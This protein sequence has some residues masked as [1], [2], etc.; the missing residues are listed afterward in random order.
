MKLVLRL[1]CKIRKT[2]RKMLNVHKEKAKTKIGKERRKL[3]NFNSDYEFAEGHLIAYL[4]DRR[5]NKRLQRQQY[6]TPNNEEKV[7][8]D[9]TVPSQ[10]HHDH[11]MGLRNSLLCLFS[12]S[13][14]RCCS[15]VITFIRRVYLF[16]LTLN[17]F[18]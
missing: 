13:L 8:Q 11:Q 12:F 16:M 5:H 15:C 3:Q 9:A 2:W 17:M 1:T 4:N 7:K 10:D 6:T 18:S 14:L